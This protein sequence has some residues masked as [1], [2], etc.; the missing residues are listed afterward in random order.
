M[1]AV[2]TND[3]ARRRRGLLAWPVSAAAAVVAATMMATPLGAQDEPAQDEPALED[4]IPGDPA[5]PIEELRVFSEVFGL[6]KDDYV[7][8]VEDIDLLRKAIGGMLSGLDPHSSYLDP[9]SFEEI[10][11]GTEG[12]FGGLGIEVTQENGLIK[13]VT[14]IDG[15][16]AHEAGILPGD[17]I[18]RLDDTPVK[19][20]SLDDAVRRMRGEPGTTINLTIIR[21][22]RNQPLEVTLERAEIKIASVRSQLIDDTIAYVRVTQFQADTANT[23]RSQIRDLMDESG[24]DLR[25]LILDLRNNPGGILTGA[26][27]V[28]DVFLEEGVI[29]S[30]R[31]RDESDNAEYRATASDMLDDV[32]LVVLVNSGSASASEIVAG[33]LQDHRRAVVMGSKTFG[34]GSV[35]T[36]LPLNNGAALKITTARYY[37][38]S[39][40]SIQATG[41]E[42]DIP[43]GELVFSDDNTDEGADVREVNLAGH[44]ENE[45][46][47]GASA[48]ETSPRSVVE[49]DPLV[50]EARNLL[51]ALD[52]VGA[53]Q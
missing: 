17:I 39:G 1:P 34:K 33:A 13:V 48:A 18:T 47:D 21:E 35:Q 20:L 7:E 36:I 28:A 23:M 52:I 9:E 22:G 45:N 29:V 12:R 41:I 16:P 49:R 32:P 19:G 38:P 30:T 3:P 10:Q 31:G 50:L 51:K 40:R 5:L 25:G 11:I 15:T 24:N 6:I 27:S 46:G 43:A 53:R 26:V 42:P 44:L 14:P 37:T 4:S 2:S 8:P